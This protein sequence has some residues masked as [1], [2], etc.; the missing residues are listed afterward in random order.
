MYLGQLS[1]LRE[2]LRQSKISV[3]L[4]A[5]DEEEL[6]NQEGD[7]EPTDSLNVEVAEVKVSD[8]VSS[9]SPSLGLRLTMPQILLRTV[10]NFQG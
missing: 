10:D 4:D 8:Q 1:K 9:N 5:R 6:R 2:E 3:I 7:R